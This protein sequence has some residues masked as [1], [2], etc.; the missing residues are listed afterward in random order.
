MYIVINH[1]N[2]K[3]DLFSTLNYI[4]N[5]CFAFVLYTLDRA[6]QIKIQLENY[7]TKY[8]CEII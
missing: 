1:N 2:E 8:E 3:L 6:Y 4:I 7:N 5:L